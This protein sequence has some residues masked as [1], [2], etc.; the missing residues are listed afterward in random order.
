MAKF[1]I[2]VPTYNRLEYPMALAE[3]ICDEI[4]IYFSDNGGFLESKKDLFGRNVVVVTK[5]DEVDVFENW[6][7]AVRLGSRGWFFLPSDDDLYYA[8]MKSKVDEILAL[9]P[10]VGMIVFGHDFIDEKGTVLG[11]WLPKVEGIKKGLEAFNEFKYGVEARMPSILIN[12]EI[13][14]KSGGISTDFKLTAGDSEFV[15]RMSINYP[16]MFVREIIA[17]YRVWNGALTHKKIASQR[18][19]DEIELWM[20]K[21]RENLSTQSWSLGEVWVRHL[22]DEIRLQNTNAGISKASSLREAVRFLFYRAYPYMARP[23]TQIRTLVHLIKCYIRN[24]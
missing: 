4:D 9:N 15:Q 6:A 2:C 3:S 24:R 12:R 8:G 21:M 14:E 16:V 17:G 13:Y 7:L 5:N 18:W 22:Q 23:R 19:R 10:A 20:E 1:E 11:S